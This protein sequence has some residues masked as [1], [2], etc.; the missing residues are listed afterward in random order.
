[1][2]VL[3]GI[4]SWR[5]A[6]ATTYAGWSIAAATGWLLACTIALGAIV[7]FAPSW[8]DAVDS[9]GWLVPPFAVGFAAQIV[10]GASSYLLPVVLG[11]GPFAA[12]VSA[13]ELDRA[14]LFRVL[15]INGGIVVYLLPVPSLVKVVVSFV[16]F[17]A[18]LVFLVLAVRAAMAGRRA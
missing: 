17:L 5:A 3:E 10:I 4:R 14:A 15:L 16:V 12:R 18:L 9:L 6:P 13:A 2:I 1:L 8:A 7:V 11:G